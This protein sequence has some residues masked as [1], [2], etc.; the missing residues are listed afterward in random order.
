LV[1][2]ELRLSQEGAGGVLVWQWY[3]VG[4]RA[5]ASEFAVKGFEALAFVTGRT[6]TEVVITLAT[7]LDDLD[8]ARGRLES[9]VASAP[10][11]VGSGFSARACGG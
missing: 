9:F 10:A 11:C 3:R 5:T 7:P 4:D 6:P 8:Q 1:I 2:R